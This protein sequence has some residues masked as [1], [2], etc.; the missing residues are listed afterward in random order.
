M[1]GSIVVF[2]SADLVDNLVAHGGDDLLRV[3]L[4]STCG[5]LWFA[6][7]D[8]ALAWCNYGW[9]RHLYRAA[10]HRWLERVEAEELDH[11]LRYSGHP[12]SATTSES[13]GDSDDP[14]ARPPWD[15]RPW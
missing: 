10:Y 8:Q 5:T 11:L 12:P 13:D 2:G 3:R 6:F 1:Q 4:W 14:W 15:T 9:R 7:Y